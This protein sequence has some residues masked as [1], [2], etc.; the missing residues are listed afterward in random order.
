LKI[1]NSKDQ[2]ARD[3]KQKEKYLTLHPDKT[4]KTATNSLVRA[5]VAG[6]G[7]W[8]TAKHATKK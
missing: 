5:W 6:K 7:G 4:E 1:D 8:R 2:S 3:A